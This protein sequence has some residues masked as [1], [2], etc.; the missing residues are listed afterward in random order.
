MSAFDAM[1]KAAESANLKWLCDDLRRCHLFDLTSVSDAETVVMD[2]E[3]VIPFPQFAI[4]TSHAVWLV[5][6]N[7]PESVR[8]CESELSIITHRK[9]PDGPAHYLDFTYVNI[10]KDRDPK[11][12]GFNS[13]NYTLAVQISDDAGWVVMNKAAKKLSANKEVAFEDVKLISALIAGISQPSRFIVRMIPDKVWPSNSPKIPRQHQRPIYTLLNKEEI[14]TRF[15]VSQPRVGEHA[16][17]SPH[18]RRAHLRRLSSD[19]FVNKVGQVVPVK[20]CWVGP[21]EFQQGRKT[22]KVLYDL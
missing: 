5:V 13:V 9:T 6:N 10:H 4:E 11:Y 17:P 14:K 22:Y 1:C 2:F 20:S 12:V 7:K 3:A 19:K 16:D 15:L 8:L 21:D 18:W